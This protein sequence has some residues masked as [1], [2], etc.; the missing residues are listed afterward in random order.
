[1]YRSE[2]KSYF[3]YPYLNICILR[4]HEKLLK[5]FAELTQKRGRNCKRK[6]LKEAKNSEKCK[7][8]SV[9][10]LLPLRQTNSKFRSTSLSRTFVSPSFLVYNI[11]IFDR[12]YNLWVTDLFC[13]IDLWV[14]VNS[15]LTNL[16]SKTVFFVLWISFV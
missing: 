13:V 6:R 2:R 1:M 4:V 15:W 9:V 5:F 16:L 12:I 10:A 7:F 8:T 14:T 3:S 11:T